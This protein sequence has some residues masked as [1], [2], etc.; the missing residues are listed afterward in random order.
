M[1][2]LIVPQKERNELLVPHSSLIGGYF[3]GEEIADKMK[4]FFWANSQHIK[5]TKMLPENKR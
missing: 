4:D 2:E 1:K 3:I 5:P